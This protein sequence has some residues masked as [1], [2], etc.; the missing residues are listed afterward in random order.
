MSIIA[1]G[2]ITLTS[3]DETSAVSLSPA[4]CVIR[5]DF[6]GDNPSLD[7]AYTDITLRQ[8]ENRIAINSTNVSVSS[9][10][11][12]SIAV[13]FTTIDQYTQRLKI[14][15]IPTTILG[16]TVQIA[17]TYSS[18][19]LNA[20]FQFSVNRE[21][22]MLD[23]IQDWE[24]RKTSIS[25]NYILTPKIYAGKMNSQNEL[26][27]VYMGPDSVGAG[28]YG[29]KDDVEVFHLNSTGAM[30]GG[31]D[32]DNLGIKT[33]DGKLK[34][35]SEGSIIASDASG[36]QIY[37]LFKSGEA[38]FAK[39]NV[40]L[41]AD[42]SA[43]FTGSIT[44]S[45]GSI[46]GW[47]ITSRAIYKGHIVLDSLKSC[48]GVSASEVGSSDI[49]G[50]AFS[51]YDNVKQNGGVCMFYTSANGYGLEGFLPSVT[52]SGSTT[53]KSVFQLGSTN[54]IAGWS[55][56]EN[57]LRS[58]YLT[59]TN[60][61]GYTGAYFSS[62]DIS[63]VVNSGLA[64]FIDSRTGVYIKAASGSVVMAGVVNGETL[65]ELGDTN[66]IAG[67][68]F[69]KDTFTSQNL[70]LTNHSGD[71]G[72]YFSADSI[73][74]V[75]L[76]DLV[77][78]IDAGT[79]VY[80]K[81]GSG[82][83][84]LSGVVS[85]KTLFKLGS[86]GSKIAAWNFDDTSLWIGTNTIGSN[87]F[88]SVANSMI[89]RSTGI[90]GNKWALYADGSGKLADGKFTWNITNNVCQ[91]NIDGVL[92]TGSVTIGGVDT[93]VMVLSKTIMVRNSNNVVNAGMSAEG[94]ADAS[95]RFWAG[96]TYENRANSSTPF[97]VTQNGK[98]YSSNAEITGYI[99][100]T[101]GEI[102]GWEINQ[103]KLRVG[104]GT[105]SGDYTSN[106]GT[107]ILSENGLFGHNWGL[108]SDG[109]GKLA[110]G[111]LSWRLYDAD[112][113]DPE[114]FPGQ[115]DSR[116]PWLTFQGKVGMDSVQI[117]VMRVYEK[118]AF[119][120]KFGITMG[121]IQVND[122]PGGAVTVDADF[123]YGSIKGGHFI[124]PFREPR[125]SM[126]SKIQDSSNII[127]DGTTTIPSGTDYSGMMLTVVMPHHTGSELL[128]EMKLIGSFYYPKLYAVNSF[129]QVTH[130]YIVTSITSVTGGIIRLINIKGSWVILS[131]DGVDS[132][133]FR[134][135]GDTTT[136]PP[137]FAVE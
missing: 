98:L 52:Q 32:I 41:H 36:N 57:A 121:S 59:F 101:S 27:G 72:A 42:G 123:S 91:V 2:S 85:G 89:L 62:Y 4:S 58:Q 125:I 60:Q 48:L 93:S 38:S 106:A 108:Y 120:N 111:A 15:S 130:Y 28:L 68:S 49:T 134:I 86:G 16:G 80:I 50:N 100:A 30:I 109:S 113:E 135:A 97:R 13:S 99:K 39:G 21:S 74:S 69:T 127:V 3:L 124:T 65:F 126:W 132:Q 71:A 112:E 118:I 129:G 1:K 90:Y 63:N 88:A 37:G 103:G 25:G 56:N 17:V 44:A 54:Q 24:S 81:A 136:T 46:G 83:A 45:G 105:I 47:S 79:G 33:L 119:E 20:T 67:W 9:K 22:T 29:Y 55:F 26:T 104:N 78:H 70:L 96:G 7:N 75:D 117:N 18:I 61:A 51:F 73:S 12:N 131:M 84:I 10:S 87:G 19:T 23:W 76:S 6:D 102:G 40:L 82:S 11:N 122:I 116:T 137:N 31:W 8:G 95:I 77:D 64:T 94:A 128:V 14:T 34:L 5:A 92:S 43:S 66:Q 110:G 133:T 107:I 35:L 114:P 115:G 53:Y